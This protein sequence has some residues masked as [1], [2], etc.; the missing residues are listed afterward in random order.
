MPT[1]GVKASSGD[2]CYTEPSSVCSWV[3]R[4]TDNNET[5]ASIADWFIARPLEILIVLTVTSIIVRLSRRMIRN[6]IP[7]IANPRQHAVA[8]LSKIGIQVPDALSTQVYDSRRRARVTSISRA[9]SSTV[10]VVIWVL[11]LFII[12]A[13][14]GVNLAPLVAGAGIAG[15][16][17]GFGAQSLVKDCIAGLFMLIEDQYGIGDIVDL[18]EAQGVVE[19]V[20]LRTTV[21]RGVDGT[22]WHVPNGVVQR[23]GNKSQQWSVAVLDVD[24]AYDTDLV[25][26]RELLHRAADE[27]CSSERFSDKV[28][29][30]PE[31]LGVEALGVDGVTLRLIVKVLPGTQFDL[32]R[33][34]REHVKAAFD[35]ASIEIPFPQRTVWNRV[36]PS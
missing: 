7:R 2:E 19:T 13:I 1:S 8:G 4:K 34:L 29:E 35:A 33:A 27:L 12:V 21:L 9:L 25:S 5:L 18:G 3:Y 28:L 16:A 36:V 10:T 17:L 6:S 20:A 24:V 14:L 32:Q 30:S 23:V 31:V 11:A 26:A 15:V 22:V